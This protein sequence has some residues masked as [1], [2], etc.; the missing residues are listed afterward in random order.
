M[1]QRIALALVALALALAPVRPA[2][3]GEAAPGAVVFD[4][5]TVRHKPGEVEG[6]DKTKV[7]VGTVELVDGR[8]GKA[9]RFTFREGAKG[10]FFTG[11]AAATPEWDEAEGL[12]F[13]VK[14]DGSA[15]WGG[16]ELIDGS[17]YGLRYGFCFPIDSTEWTRVF[18]AWRDLLPE[19]SGP[20]VDAKSGY[21]PSRFRN[22]WLGKWYYWREYPAHAFAIDQVRLEQRIPG[23]P[24]PPVPD[25]GLA[26]VR[27]LV[28]AGKPVTIV[29]MGDSLT[30]KRHWANREMLW[31]EALAADLKKKCGVEV[32]LVNPAIGGTTLTQNLILMPRWLKDVPQPDLVTVCFGY[33]DWDNG[34]RGER[35]AEYLRAGVDRI[36]R[37]TGG[38]A[39]VLLMTT[40]PAHGRWETMDE[41]AAAVRAVA[42][43]KHTGLADIAAAFRQAGSPDEALRQGYW[44]WDKTHLGPRGHAVV[45]ETVGAALVGQ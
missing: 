1:Q 24:D 15:S 37:L 10:G 13:Y 42:A 27:A 38:R 4:M 33:N 22:V 28:K 9:C 26:R 16:L 36:R 3:A 19:R 30:D 43:E 34:V 8:E 5:D 21:A 45:A 31:A 20:L 12:S 32:R 29:T 6:P 18:V 17:D 44:A 14:G 40:C 25:D 39:D 35:F 41:L 23:P 7:P 11:W 2:P